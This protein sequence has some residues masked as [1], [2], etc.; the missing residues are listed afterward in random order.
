MNVRL[1]VKEE[2]ERQGLHLAHI[3][4]EAKLAM[5]TARRY[6]Y[7]SSTGLAKDTGTLTEVNLQILGLIAALLRV[8]PGDLLEG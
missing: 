6:W 5:T 4:R 1:R 8:R 2:A 3:Q 7:S